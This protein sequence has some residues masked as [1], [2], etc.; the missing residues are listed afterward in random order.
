MLTRDSLPL[1]PVLL[2]SG[3]YAQLKPLKSS[4]S[5]VTTIGESNLTLI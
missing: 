1:K 2:I 5:S 4:S 3:D